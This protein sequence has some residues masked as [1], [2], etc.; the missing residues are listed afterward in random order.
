MN[1]ENIDSLIEKFLNDNK[2]LW[3]YELMDNTTKRNLEKA[4]YEHLLQKEIYSY[5]VEVILYQLG[6]RVNLTLKPLYF[7]AKED[8]NKNVLKLLNEWY[9]YCYKTDK[10]DYLQITKDVIDG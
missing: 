2:E 8:I 4:I 5:D 1:N 6:V 9:D 3:L 7:E 10:T